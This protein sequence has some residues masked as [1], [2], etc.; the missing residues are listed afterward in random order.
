[1]RNKF[2]LSGVL[3]F[4]ATGL[5][6]AQFWKDYSEKD[7]QWAGES[8][9]LAGRQYQSVGKTEKGR[10]YMALGRLIYP[11][12]DPD[13]IADEQLPSAAELLTRGR[14]MAIGADSSAVPTGAIDSFFLRFVSAM[15]D[16]D[17][18]AAVDFLDGSVYLT[19]LTAEVTRTDAQE[20]LDGFFKE[21]P[22]K[23]LGPSA[24][25]DLDSVVVAR[26]P[27]AMR[28][29][30]GE[31]YTL[32]VNA[33]KDYSEDVSFWDMKQ[34]FFIHREG[35]AWRIFS[36]GQSPPPLTWS[37]KTA[38]AV[39]AAAPAGAREADTNTAISE[40]FSGFI[41]ALLT[42]DAEGAVEYASANI[43]FL[44]LRQTVTRDELKT[45]LQGYFDNADFGGAAPADVLDL[46]SVFVEQAASPVEE[47]ADPVYMLNAKARVDL[48]GSLPL[49]STYQSYYYTKDGN[50][51]KI[52]AIL[53]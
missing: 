34:Q 30:W 21:A 32:R 40:A 1:M 28:K 31:T 23:G 5:L 24:V 2:V 33:R 15:L 9:W 41:S 37:P 7:R 29:A 18:A 36:F 47:V 12:L 6:W 10:D 27:Q 43:R 50:D 35:G 51:W 14:T 26:P 20:A 38:A 11:Q 46:D 42:K 53:M 4:L 22:L 16:E 39:A 52:F 13:T 25:Y 44:K 3:L 45:S 49:W 48:T 19:R 8:Y 17:A